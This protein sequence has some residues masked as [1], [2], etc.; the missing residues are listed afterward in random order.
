MEFK[1]EKFSKVPVN[2]FEPNL[3]SPEEQDPEWRGILIEAPKEVIFS[4]GDSEKYIPVCGYYQLDMDR[5]KTS[6][7]LKL[8]VIK[9]GDD[10]I[11]SGFVVEEDPSPSEPEPFPTDSV[12]E[13]DEGLVLGSYFNPD[14]LNFVRI[15]LITG[16]YIIFA[17]YAGMKS[18]TVNIKIQVK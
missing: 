14:L 11:F 18:N 5:L 4:A 12:E 8:N 2:T 7:P 13:E 16:E 9:Q 3:C 17:E 10:K 6:Q 1:P 15:P